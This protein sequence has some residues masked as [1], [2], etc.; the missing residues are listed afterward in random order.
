LLTEQK[1]AKIIGLIEELRAD[2]P[3][4]QNRRDWEA[5]IMQQSTNP[6][7]V[8]NILEENL[9]HVADADELPT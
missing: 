9:N 7:V 6:Q 4:L 2:S 1:T 3:D 8:L 5:E